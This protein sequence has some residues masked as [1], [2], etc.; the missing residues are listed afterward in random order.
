[1]TYKVKV[2]L[3]G[4]IEKNITVYVGTKSTNHEET[5]INAVEKEFGTAGKVVSFKKKKV[6]KNGFGVGVPQSAQDK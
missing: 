3:Y 1:M 5:I 6:N 4:V 2:K